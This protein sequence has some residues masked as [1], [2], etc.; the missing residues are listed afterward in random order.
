[1][2]KKINK[3]RPDFFMKVVLLSFLV[4]TL[5]F[6]L[7][8]FKSGDFDIRSFAKKEQNNCQIIGGVCIS[9]R[10][11]SERGGYNVGTTGCMGNTTCCFLNG[12][13]T[14]TPTTGRL[15]YQGENIRVITECTEDSTIDIYIIDDGVDEYP[16][17]T[18]TY[19]ITPSSEYIYM[20]YTS[21]DNLNSSATVYGTAYSIRGSTSEVIQS[22]T[23]YVAGI[24]HG[25]Y[26]VLI[27][28]LYEPIY[29]LPFKTPVC[30]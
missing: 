16:N 24:A 21:P 22:D 25:S 8:L 5:I 10:A 23:E 29:E 6:S 19:L 27:P 26:S 4:I 3:F 20:A 28:E 18:W 17:G 30:N 11:C 13:P 15:E 12:T 2:K 9:E 1:M 14:P 7:D